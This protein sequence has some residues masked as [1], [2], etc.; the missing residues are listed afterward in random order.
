[1]SQRKRLDRE[2]LKFYLLNLLLIYRPIFQIGGIV[3]L[4]YAI[5]TISLYPFGSMIALAVA[6]FLFLLRFSF[7]LTLYISKFGVWLGTTGRK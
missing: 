7:A 6:A 2:G 3:I 5:A 4:V 1:M